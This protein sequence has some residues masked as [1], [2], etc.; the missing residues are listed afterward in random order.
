[1]H[2]YNDIVQGSDEWHQLRLGKITGSN[3]YKLTGTEAARKKYLYDKASEIV[4]GEKCDA[5]SVTNQHMQRGN[6]YE[7]LARLKYI[8]HTLNYVQEVGFVQM[9]EYVACSPDG[10]VDTDGMIE[11]K[12]PDSSKYL[13]QVI[14]I[15]Q[16]NE[17]DIPKEH[18]LQM[19]FNLLV[20]N[21]EWCDYV[22]YNPKHDIENRGLF[23]FRVKEDLK[24]QLM[25]KHTID[26]AITEIKQYIH[27][28]QL[29]LT[30]F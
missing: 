29:T 28:Y 5:D 13:G 24:T 9:N 2:T 26:T 17:K 7:A 8:A 30:D 11:I 14:E 1:M 25:I 27:L 3:F 18:Y 23:I 22:L 15:S 21:R 12:V 16:G 19:Q 4:S 10:L 6:E 20:C